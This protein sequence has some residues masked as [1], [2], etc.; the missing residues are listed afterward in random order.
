MTDREF[1]LIMEAFRHLATVRR[2]MLSGLE[3][4]RELLVEITSE[5]SEVDENEGPEGGGK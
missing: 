3:T 2:E 1:A 4:L 5:V